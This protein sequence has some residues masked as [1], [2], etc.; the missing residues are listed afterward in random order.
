[1]L[2]A[3]IRAAQE[4]L[5]R[6]VDLRG[7]NA[8]PEEPIAID[9]KRFAASL[10]MAW[11]AGETRLTHRRPYRRIK[12]Y[13]KR[14]SMLEPYER[15]FGHRLEAEPTLSAV[16]VLQRLINADPARFTKKRLRTVQL[17]VKAWRV[18]TAERI[19]LDGDWMNPA[20]HV[21]STTLGNILR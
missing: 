8:K 14:P 11:Q 10:R 12:P 6:R 4:D 16:T 9:L 13:P 19:I 7:L 5:G 1:M 3:G 2:F 18:E 17:A 15:G 21:G 20:G